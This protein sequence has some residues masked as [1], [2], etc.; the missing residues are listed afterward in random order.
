MTLEE[1][2]SELNT[3]TFWRE[4]TY[5]ETWFNPRPQ[6][7]VELADGIVVLGDLAYVF[8]LKERTN[9]TDDP[10]AERRWFKDKVLRKATKQIRDTVGYLSDNE[11][12]ALTNA[13]GHSVG[14][15]GSDLVDIK[16]LVIFQGSKALPED[17]WAT[18]YHV[19]ETVGFIHVIAAHDY[20]GI[21]DKLRVPNDIRLYLEYRE[22]VLPR[23]REARV[24]VEEPDILVGFF[25]EDELPTPGSI[26][27]LR[28]FV[29]DLEAFDLTPILS[30]L[31]THIQNPN[32][33]RDYYNILLEFSRCSRSVWREFKKRLVKSLEAC[34]AGEFC[35]PFR[36]HVPADDCTFMIAPLDPQ[37]P[38]SGAEGERVRTGALALFTEAA[39]YD[40][41]TTRAVGLLVSKDGEE[42]CLDWCLI[43]SPWEED[44]K[45]RH[46]IA[47]TGI[48]REVKERNVDSF[49]FRR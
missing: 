39:K 1:L 45:L 7:R 27:R 46:F 49:Y 9:P 10:E 28:G 31:L 42:V 35:R 40:A 29:Q 5:P 17:C 8:Q 33:N 34:R 16:K 18:K 47:D 19:S 14:I 6:Q 21:L 3:A 44:E 25:Q 4:F 24:T 26:E 41:K 48:F 12:I 13:Q 23:L 37:W 36:F 38:A 2:T 30:Q 22:Q 15:Y 11:K 32:S 43:D 20:L